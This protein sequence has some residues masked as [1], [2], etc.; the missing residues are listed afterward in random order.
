[1]HSTSN[2]ED[3][4]IGSGKQLWLSINKHGKTNH[5]KEILEFLEN[6]QELK[7]REVQLV[8]SDLLNDPLCMNL[9]QGG[10]GG[11]NRN[12]ADWSIQQK[13]DITVNATIRSVQLR[14]EDPEFEK[15]RAS[16][17]SMTMKKKIVDGEY[18]PPSWKGKKLK[19]D[20]RKHIGEA[21]SVSQKGK[22]NSQYGKIWIHNENK[23]KLIKKKTLIS[24]C[25]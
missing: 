5:S 19:N 6:R 9:M 10:K 11:L 7:I 2:L 13:H 3:G 21:N 8:N 25:F 24:I 15:K 4:Y 17:F 23:S 14:K 12:Y 20:H 16:N 18:S 1:M 22:K